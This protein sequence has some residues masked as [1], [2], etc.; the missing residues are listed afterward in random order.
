MST[1][2]LLRL[3]WLRESAPNRLQADLGTP[4]APTDLAS[5][6]QRD[7]PDV[8]AELSR[9]ILAELPPDAAEIEIHLP[10]LDRTAWKNRNQ[11]LSAAAFERNPDGSRVQPVEDAT[12]ATEHEAML[13]LA[14]CLPA[15][16]P[17]QFELRFGD[18]ETGLSV[19]LPAAAALAWKHIPAE[20]AADF[21]TEISRA[22]VAMQCALRAWL[23]AA[24]FRCLDSYADAAVAHP[25]LAYQC[26]RPYS[27]RNRMDYTW[28]VL[29]PKTLRSATRFAARPLQNEFDRIQR[30]LAA[31]GKPDIERLYV[32][33]RAGEA[34]AQVLKGRRLLDGLL[35]AD[36][37]LVEEFI[38]L[39]S[40]ARDLSTPRQLS[41]AAARFAKGMHTKLRRLYAGADYTWLGP[42][43]LVS[44]LGALRDAVLSETRRGHEQIERL[45][46]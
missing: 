42:L 41:D 37:V 26:T 23:P 24:H 40:A 39:S 35:V 6:L 19:R 21:F 31:A 29:S 36:G 33:A 16:P 25:L 11:V 20:S 34:L 8:S 44:A 2:P 22:S 28:D 30:L 32:P 38:R 7:V 43:L 12:S 3:C 9:R 10:C 13:A 18:R 46:A 45:A 27:G 4:L 15:A 1:Q 5:R 17:P 14:A